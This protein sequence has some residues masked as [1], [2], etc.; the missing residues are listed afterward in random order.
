MRR[1]P[2][3]PLALL[4]LAACDFDQ[5]HNPGHAGSTHSGTA[6]APS[7]GSAGGA[8]TSA[9][10]TSGGG[11]A[12]PT[13]SSA[14]SSGG[15]T[16]GLGG[17]M[18]MGAGGG[19]AAG[20]GTAGGG[21]MGG[22]PGSDGGPDGGGAGGGPA[23]AALDGPS[24][25]GHALEFQG[26][27]GYATFNRPIQDDFTLEAWIQPSATLAPLTGS[28]IWNGYG[29]V[30]ADMIGTTNDFGSSIVNGKFAF[31]VGNPDTN[32]QSTT[33]IENGRWTHVAATRSMATGEISVIGP[34][35]HH[36][37]RRYHRQPLLQRP[38]GRGPRLECRA[39]AGRDR[40]D[41]APAARGQRTWS[42]R[43]LSVR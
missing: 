20:G 32:V 38:D 34:S 35:Q 42:R 24:C 17:A 39:H 18:A 9:T 21:A 10:A 12:A 15:T 33:A 37:R 22:A 13:R 2:F 16:M 25:A 19:G 40:V 29:I 31:G 1:V 26:M 11:D 7:G 27:I 8:G 36:A 3:F 30:Y 28:N 5:L 41:D 6:G 14:T 23:D 43:L 4:W